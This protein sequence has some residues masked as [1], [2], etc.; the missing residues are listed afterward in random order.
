MNR[1]LPAVLLFCWCAQAQIRVASLNI[2]KKH[3]A[4]EVAKI[5]GQPDLRRADVL[6]LQE[7]VDGP[8]YHVASAVAA[9]I[10]FREYF[11]PAFQLNSRFMEG[12]A[13]V[14]RCPIRAPEVIRLPRNDLH[15]HTR[16]R[17]ALAV[18]LACPA[19]PLRVINTQLDDRINNDDKL[20]QIAELWKGTAGF[21][22]PSLIGGDFNTGNFLWLTHL[23]P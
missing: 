10:G 20:R 15:F 18:T 16:G 12:L 14:S 19:G 1:L 4:A 6:L 11:A 8:Q 7:V 23:I 17:I 21:N 2:A 22:G 13:V 3:G 5:A 9:A